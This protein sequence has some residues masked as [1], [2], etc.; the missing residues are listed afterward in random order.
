[1]D[2]LTLEAIFSDEFI[3]KIALKPGFMGLRNDNKVLV[4]LKEAEQILLNK[5]HELVASTFDFSIKKGTSNKKVILE[6][7]KK[8]L[9]FLT[10]ASRYLLISNLLERIDILKFEVALLESNAAGFC[11]SLNSLIEHSTHSSVNN[12]LEE[13]ELLEKKN[14]W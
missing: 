1:M 2:E 14:N 10:P 4:L 12:C 7:F 6:E 9:L 8:S 3:N 5:K 11:F 13:K